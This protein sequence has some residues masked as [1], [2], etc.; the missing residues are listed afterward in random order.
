MLALIR[1]FAKSP[2]ASGL[3]GLLVLSFAVF[4]ISDV[5]KNAGRGDAVIQAGG[6]S[7]SGA[8]FR[9]MFD[10]YL[11]GQAQQNGGQTP[12]I[13]EAAAQGADQQVLSEVVVEES[14]NAAI[15]RAGVRP[16][17]ELV[18]GELAKA[19][20]FRNPVTGAFDKAAYQAFLRE[21][22]I[23]PQEIE[24]SLRDQIAQRQ[25]LTGL[26]AGLQA[27][28]TF[29]AVQAA[30]DTEARDF[31]Y[32]TI[33]ASSFPAPAKPT[34]AELQAFL[35]ENAAHLTRPETRV[36]SL[37]RFSAALLAPTLPVDEAELKKRFDFEKDSLSVAEKRTVVQIPLRSPAQAA[38]VVARLKRGETPAAVARSVGTQPVIVTD[39]PKTAV[40]DPTVAAAAFSMAQGEVR[41]PVQGGLGAS[42]VQVTSVTP[43]HDVTLDEARPKLEAEVRKAA[44][45]AKAEELAGKY[46]DAR[47]GGAN[48]AEAVAKTGVAASQLPPFSAQGVAANGQPLPVPK[49]LIATAFALPKGGESELLQVGPGESY[50]IRVDE[51]H[52]PAPI[53]L[54][55]I[56]APLTARLFQ[57][58][59]A[60]AL[61]AKAEA[62]A[63]QARAKGSLDGLAGPVQHVAG[64]T[65]VIA[66][67]QNTPY[68]P[69]VMA[70]VFASKVGEV[71]TAAVQGASG[72]PPSFQ[73]VR[74]ER[75]TP[76][77]PQTVALAGRAG[78][79]ATSVGLFEDLSAHLRDASRAQIKPR[80]DPARARAALGLEPAA[81]PAGGPPGGA[82]RPV[83]DDVFA[84]AYVAGRPQVLLRRVVDDLETPVSAFLKIGRGRPYAFLFESV[85][86][87][88]WR[89]RYSVIALDP[90]L[91]WRARGDTAEVAHGP[92]AVA[93]EAFS[94]EPSGALASLRALVEASRI[95]LPPELPPMAA[96]LF[97]VLGYD[98][99]R[100][101]EPLGPHNP[102]PLDLPDAV[103]MRPRVVA[104][105]DGV[106]QEI[107]LVAPVRPRPGVSAAEA[108]GEAQARLEAV[109]QRLRAPPE[110]A[111]EPARPASPPPTPQATVDRAAYRE[112]VARAKR[113]IE[114]GDIFQVVPSRRL[115][116][117]HPGDPFAFYRALRRLNPSPF[118]YFLDFGGFQLAGSSPEIL[119]RY[120]DGRV[121]IRPIAGTRPRGR[122]PAHD[123]ELEAELL[124]D[125]QGAGRAPDAAGPRPQRR[126]PRHRA[127]AGR[128]QPP[129]PR[130]RDA[131]LRRRAL[132]PR[133]A[134]RLQR[135][136]RGDRPARSRR[137]DPHRASRRHPLG[138]AQGAGHADH[139]RAGD[140]QARRRL[141]RRVRLHRRG[142]RGGH[143]NR[144]AH[145]PVQGRDHVRPGR[146]RRGGRQRPR[147]RVRR[148]RAQGP[149]PAP[150][151]AGGVA[152]RGLTPVSAPP[153]S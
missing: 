129:G 59:L 18:L 137:R 134:H 105:F 144:P 140:G 109:A 122:T 94:P 121:T 148:D 98:L 34:D 136:G 37:V 90:D 58:K 78:A 50:A 81:A 26:V 149:R 70:R 42:V 55:E 12:T 99:V 111:P 20:R 8:Q 103:M 130:A 104:V 9:A 62:V 51:V 43:G 64:V 67:Q 66:R 152:V 91:V 52:P 114:A 68:A 2:A 112:I 14:A 127:R 125:S 75:I 65:R 36:V 28:A 16:A 19:P 110:R 102:D 101:A 1:R 79:Q 60:Q 44:A 85:E 150:R 124:A 139:R 23:S 92:E 29:T 143:R 123:A 142:R 39:A 45:A 22:R 106:A 32:V 96:G 33:G 25:F 35:K 72:Q 100:L 41:G 15:A 17:D 47:S 49:K 54:E 6:R 84:A 5:F 138:R 76:G 38:D 145:R 30:F 31:S 61:Q 82:P 21:Q 120:R 10:R 80:V 57:Q 146:R 153:P 151:R 126:G 88:A 116:A 27:P 87:G 11:Q 131:E 86:G 71:G 107:L 56:R 119:V 83:T 63:A 95:D 93:A 13:Q 147:R 133:H 24:G 113:Y 46:D 48:F 40:A 115:E 77:S 141:R 132:Q 7:V 3:L 108:C 53:G 73:V 135:R 74:L 128:R 89:G 118:L 69:A 97:G 4:G 117:P